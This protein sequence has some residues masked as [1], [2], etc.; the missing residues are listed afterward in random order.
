MFDVSHAW[1]KLYAARRVAQSVL[2]GLFLAFA[3][4]M[5]QSHRGQ[6][7]LGAFG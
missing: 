1:R 4:Q 6:Q 2:R 3:R 5:R 7:N